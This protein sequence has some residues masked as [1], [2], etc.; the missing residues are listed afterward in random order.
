MSMFQKFEARREKI[1]IDEQRPAYLNGM[2]RSYPIP[3][4]VGPA[5]MHLSPKCR[6]T[7]RLLKTT[8][9]SLAVSHMAKFL[10]A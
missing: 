2:N 9:T 5:P 7:L 8:E 4:A 6:Y 1:E 3:A 10:H